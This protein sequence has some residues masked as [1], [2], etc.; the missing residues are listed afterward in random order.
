MNTVRDN[1]ETEARVA[2]DQASPSFHRRS[3]PQRALR[4]PLAGAGTLPST[5]GPARGFFRRFSFA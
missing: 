3:S 5:A 1:P 4:T 2:M